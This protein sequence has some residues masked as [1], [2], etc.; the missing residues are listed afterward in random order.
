MCYST[1]FTIYNYYCTLQKNK[2]RKNTHMTISVRLYTLSF[3]Y[4]K[5]PSNKLIILHTLVIQVHMY[6][7]EKIILLYGSIYIRMYMHM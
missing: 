7:Y 1:V 5:N 4:S 2:W 3:I 6:M